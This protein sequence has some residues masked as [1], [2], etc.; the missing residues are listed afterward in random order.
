MNSF[1]SGAASD[2][3]VLSTDGVPRVKKLN[4]CHVCKKRVGLTGKLAAF[5]VS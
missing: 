1:E 3:G 4:R 5:Y 2:P